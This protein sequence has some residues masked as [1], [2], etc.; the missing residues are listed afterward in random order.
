MISGLYYLYQQLK[1]EEK[2][3]KDISWSE[4]R[5]SKLWIR[6]DKR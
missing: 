1:E 3:N 2:I 5:K 4:F 6:K